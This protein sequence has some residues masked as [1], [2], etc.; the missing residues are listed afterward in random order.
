M[1]NNNIYAESA[2]LNTASE[3]PVRKKQQQIC[4][5]SAYL[6]TPSEIFGEKDIFVY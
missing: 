2:H 6:N 4:A 5:E 1:K 3:I